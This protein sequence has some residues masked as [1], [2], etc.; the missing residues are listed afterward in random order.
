MIPGIKYDDSP[1]RRR[2]SKAQLF[3]K[4]NIST[5]LSNDHQNSMF[6]QIADISFRVEGD[7]PH[8]SGSAD[9]RICPI[10]RERKERRDPVHRPP[11]NG[12][13]HTPQAGSCCIRTTS[14]GYGQ[15]S[16]PC[17]RAGTSWTC[18]T[19]KATACACGAR[20]TA[21]PSAWREP[22]HPQLLRF[23]LWTGY[24]VMTARSRRIA[25]HG[26]CIVHR[27]KPSC[28]WAK[29]AQAKART[30]ACGGSTCREQ[31][32]STTT[33]PSCGQRTGK[34]GALRQPMERENALLQTGT[35]P[36]AR[37]RTPGTGALQP[38]GAADWRPGV[39]R[40]APLLPSG[41]CLRQP[42]VR[43]HRG[44]PSRYSLTACPFTGWNAGPTGKRHCC[45]FTL[46]A[47]NEGKTIANRDFFDWAEQMLAEGKTVRFRV[48]GNSMYPLLRDR[49]DEVALRP[50]NKRKH[51]TKGTS[52]S[53]I[54]KAGTSCTA[55][56]A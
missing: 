21:P 14:T 44:K 47:M 50:R 35:L 1:Q 53:S 38:H 42:A 34:C 22:R 7:A 4:H 33:A 48:R 27:G 40:P 10:R 30:H 9:G 37:M 2:G 32:C 24:G 56:S 43:R 13:G 52:C 36:A 23:A 15:N 28:S 55:L 5:P 25:L 8:G 54:T 17:P 19:K 49:T 26:S 20:P 45:L 3:I 39:C 18:S 29:A 6:Y 51:R 16:M 11:G 31:R 12:G 41:V 46:Y